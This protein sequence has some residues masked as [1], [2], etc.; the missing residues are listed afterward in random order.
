MS[1]KKLATRLKRL[2]AD[3]MKQK[4]AELVQETSEEVLN[5]NRAQLMQGMD[6]QGNSLGKYQSESYARFKRTLNPRGVVDLKLTGSFHENFFIASEVP[7]IIW[8]YDEKTN[9]LVEKYGEDIFGLTEDNR[10]AYLVGYIRP[11]FIEYQ[12]ALLLL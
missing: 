8:S 11:R 5:M 6:S 10:K 12:K 1:I 7:L 3:E 4:L 2:S 9:D